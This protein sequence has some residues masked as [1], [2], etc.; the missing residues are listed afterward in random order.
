MPSVGIEGRDAI[1]EVPRER[2]DIDAHFDPNPDHPGTTYSRWG[3]FLGDVRR[4][5]AA[6]F[7]MSPRE[8]VSVDPQERLLLETSWEALE[9]A[10][11]R[12]D[13]LAGSNTGVFM[14]ISSTES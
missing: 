7:E 6:F 2:F 3:G 4:F 13:S 5:D 12:K 9:R 8:A 14:G 10:G 11:Y 1:T